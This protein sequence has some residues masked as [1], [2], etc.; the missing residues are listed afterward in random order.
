MSSTNIEEMKKIIAD[1][2]K[3]SSQQGKLGTTNN[4]SNHGPNKGFK[5]TKRSGSLNK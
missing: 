3:K 1:K 4:K 5:N 2:K